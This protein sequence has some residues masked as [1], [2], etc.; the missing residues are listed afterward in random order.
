MYTRAGYA[1]ELHQAFR[2]IRR[3]ALR[4]NVHALPADDKGANSPGGPVSTRAGYARE[5]HQAF[6]P[7]RIRALRALR[8]HQE[9]I[10]ERIKV[11]LEERRG[12][13]SWWTCRGSNSGPPACKAGAL[14]TELQAHD[15]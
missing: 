14:P 3:R 13:E 4:R 6:R 5:L 7:V 2:P 10:N 8:H 12:K 1:R 15:C 9:K 11:R